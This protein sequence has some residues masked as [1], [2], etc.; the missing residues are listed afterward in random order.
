MTGDASTRERLRDL[1]AFRLGLAIPPIHDDRL[2]QAVAMLTRWPDSGSG[3]V[4]PLE[5]ASWDAES[6]QQVVPWLTVGETSFLRHRQ[7]FAEIERTVLVPL[8]EDRRQRGLRR[9]RLW[10]AACSTGEEPYSLAMILDRLLPDRQDWDI[11]IIGSDINRASLAQARRAIY[12]QWSLRELDRTERERCF[13]RHGDGSYILKPSL[14]DMVSFKLLN[15]AEMSLLDSVADTA[16][17]DLIICRNALMYWTPAVQ[18]GVAQCLI[19]CLA[20][21]GWLAVSPAEAV[22]EWYRPLVPVN[23]QAAILFHKGSS[24]APANRNPAAIT[25]CRKPSLA[26]PAAEAPRRRTS[27]LPAPPMTPTPAALLPMAPP[28]GA[29]GTAR[30]LADRGQLQTA[31]EHCQALIGRDSL[32]GEAHLLLA[33]IFLELKELGPALAAARRA[34]Y[35]LPSSPAAHFQLSLV[36][37]EMGQTAQA[38]RSTMAVLSLL[39]ELPEEQPIDFMPNTTVAGLRQAASAWLGRFGPVGGARTDGRPG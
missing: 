14:R 7:W 16:D 21:D 4:E 30:A 23:L 36:Q 29:V 27:R 31:R 35:V 39:M 1:A 20:V 10:S 19:R 6:W 34:I 12:R 26:D 18:V 9:L 32:N 25:R 17:Y 22:S 38:H 8:I 15:L 37:R 28:A 2:D 5:A 13:A 3:G 11:T 24:R 33:T